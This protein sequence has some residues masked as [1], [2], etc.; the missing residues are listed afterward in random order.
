MAG[1]NLLEI[2]YERIRNENCS[3]RLHWLDHVELLF[4]TCSGAFGVSI[5]M[6]PPVFPETRA[7]VLC[8]SAFSEVKIRLIYP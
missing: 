4:Q 7:I 3:R 1:K 2:C 6:K 5:S 8:R